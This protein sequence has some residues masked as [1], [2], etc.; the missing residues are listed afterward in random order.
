MT[1][2]AHWELCAVASGS[3]RQQHGTIGTVVRSGDW[4]AT[5]LAE[6]PGTGTGLITPYRWRSI[7]IEKCS[8]S[9][10]PDFRWAA[11]LNYDCG[12][13]FMADLTTGDVTPLLQSAPKSI[14][15]VSIDRA[16]S[17]VAIAEE[18]G[19]VRL[20]DVA[21]G[22]ERTEKFE[23][24]RYTRIAF[25]PTDVLAV[26]AM[27]GN[28][29]YLCSGTDLTGTPTDLGYNSYS[30]YNTTWS[31]DGGL[32]FAAGRSMNPLAVQDGQVTPL[33]ALQTNAHVQA[34]VFLGADHIMVLKLGDPRCWQYDLRTGAQEGYQAEG[35]AL[36]CLVADPASDMLAMSYG[37]TVH[38]L[39]PDGTNR[40]HIAMAHNVTDLAMS[41]DGYRLLVATEE[42]I[43]IYGLDSA[44]LAAE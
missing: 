36:T 2:G 38:L 12:E 3:L 18:H 23:V 42:K 11:C 17:R 19:S 8:V 44:A 14:F 22:T 6:P 24:G 16:G 9:V 43:V 13:V 21:S 26:S 5:A 4:L 39:H 35:A 10:T 25:S 41:P 27:D 1:D 30:T 29:L 32:L 34:A 40:G 37:S 28:K 15:Q 33:P 7:P 20:V 31:P